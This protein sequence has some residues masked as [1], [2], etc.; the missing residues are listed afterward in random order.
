[1]AF[2][3]G[4]THVFFEDASIDLTASQPGNQ[5]RGNLSGKAEGAVDIFGLQARWIF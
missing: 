3:L 5:A 2:D 1:L 4:Y